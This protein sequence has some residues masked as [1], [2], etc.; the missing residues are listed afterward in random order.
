M[1]Y[2]SPISYQSLLLLYISHMIFYVIMPN[3]KSA[4]NDA[5]QG[6]VMNTGVT[7]FFSL[8]SVLSLFFFSLLFSLP[9][10]IVVCRNPYRK[11][12]KWAWHT[13]THSAQCVLY[14]HCIAVTPHAITHTHA[15]TQSCF[16]FAGLVRRPTPLLQLYCCNNTSIRATAVFFHALEHIHSLTSFQLC[17]IYI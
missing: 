15:H 8:P 10:Q 11:R 9:F 2:L 16:T 12:E 6:V 14:C 7:W 4:H 13:Q 5:I 1:L 3:S 17:V